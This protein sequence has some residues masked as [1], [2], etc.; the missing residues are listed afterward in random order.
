[1]TNANCELQAWTRRLGNLLA[2]AFVAM[3]ISSG[4]WAQQSG[5]R[6]SEPSSQSREPESALAVENLSRVAASAAQ[7]R[8]VLVMNPGLF[9]ELKRWVARDAAG[10]GQI[11]RDADL[12][13]DAI[14][15]R[16][17]MDV[18]FRSIAT[19]LL[20]KYGYLEA[21]VNPESA[22]GREQALLI[23]DRA[24]WLAQHQ[25]QEELANSTPPA[26]GPRSPQN[27]SSCAPRLP[28]Y[29]S[30]PQT[31][32]PSGNGNEDQQALPQNPP[33]TAPS[34]PSGPGVTSTREVRLTQVAQP[35]QDA[36]DIFFPLSGMYPRTTNV[37]MNSSAMNGGTD[38]NP[39]AGAFSGAGPSGGDMFGTNGFGGPFGAAGTGAVVTSPDLVGSQLSSGKSTQ[40][41]VTETDLVR[42]S[43]SAPALQPVELVRKA[44]PY[45]D[46]PSLYDM[47]VQA[48]PRPATPIRFGA[49]IFQSGL[50]DKD[51]I[52]MDLPAG[53]DYVLGPGDGLSINLWGSVSQRLIRT[54]DREG[55]VDMPE[56]GPLL[57]SG[58][59]LAQV[60]EDTQRALRAQFREI[61][62][63]VSLSRLRTVRVYEVGDLVNPGAYDVSALSTP[64]SALFEAGGPSPQGSIRVLKHYRG[65]QLVQTIDA[66]DLL[67]HG[68]RGNMARLESGDTIL[69]PPVGPQV[70]VEGM[71]RRPAVYE[72]RDEK[73]LADVLELAGGLLPVAALRHIEVERT[74]TY[75]KRSMLN[76]DIPDGGSSAEVDSKLQSF[77]IH[78]GDRIRI[79][80]IA[81]YNQDA[82]YVQ[83]H[84]VR[85]GKYSYRENMRVTDVIGSY[86]DLL[87]EP[88]TQYAEIIRLNAPDFR[89]TVQSFNLGDAL[90]HPDK[91]PVLQPLD[92]VRVY[93]R[94]DFED[95]PTV[96]VL[97]EVRAP[98]DYHTSGQIH[99]SDAVHLA[100][101]LGVEASTADAQVF[102]TLPDGKSEIFSV[103]LRQAL[104]GDAVDNILL[105][106]RDRILIHRNASSVDPETVSIEGEVTNP[107]R[108]PLTNNL[109]ISD[110]VRTAGGLMPSADSV[111][112]DLVRF[113]WTDQNKLVAKHESLDLA[114]VLRG[115]ADSSTVLRNGDVLTIR[116]R[117]GWNDLGASVV[118]KG[119]VKHPGTYGIRPGERLSSV[120]ERAGGFQP[121]A[122]PTGAVLERLEVREVESKQRDQMIL[123]IKDSQGAIEA[124][125]EG[126]PQ[127]KQA[128]Y[129]SLQQWQTALNEVSSNPPSGRVVIH[130]TGSVNRWKDTPAD[131]ELRS[132]DTLIV[133][134]RPNIV[135]VTGQ[136]YNPTA[137]LYHPGKSTKWYLSQSGGPTLLA[138]K[139]AIFVIRADGSVLGGKAG[140]ELW[141]GGSLSSALE[142]GDTVVVPDKALGGG[143]N[144]QNLLLG[145]QVASGVAS[146]LFIALH[147]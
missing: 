146:S 96:S 69:V 1:M 99:L 43:P 133:P 20:Q 109:R 105:Q 100:G 29:C 30:G 107:G 81:P 14:F 72:L 113:E 53:P 86:K 41:N 140:L 31:A 130:I 55:R 50:R 66:Y 92:T 144:W 12:S 112:A 134:K 28:N 131:V 98:G 137:V 74:V 8:A 46:V 123:R 49:D 19:I 77:E 32:P 128:K 126:S 39:M 75:E 115:T 111:T 102:R 57:V 10:H 125:P 110:L 62:V 16:L 33:Q 35:D 89:P 88:A 37:S 94:F 2:G 4:A 47:Y 129:V 76:L 143:P 82:I 24:K 80:P 136:V 34:Q 27:T 87:P 147:Y 5:D 6:A 56:V 122:Y 145:A 38:G 17:E 139:K 114:S 44:N 101:G 116:Q 138:D 104:A 42:R 141:S 61:S 135:M 97:G 23:Q 124:M 64:L 65:N 91:A 48:T 106:P 118:L 90:S 121:D 15:D 120:I 9:V 63:D 142:P 58:K 127:A 84:V 79:F 78:D 119:E 108:Y 117:P 45:A 40:P 73:S 67:L 11:V 83:G 95:P 103:G 54:V 85:P 3:V 22:V 60:Q 93:S 132:R 51:V 70:T 25:E 18:H 59:S 71:V 21:D 36:T 7:I 68:V 52:P 13:D 26:G